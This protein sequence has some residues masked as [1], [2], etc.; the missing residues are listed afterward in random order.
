MSLADLVF[1]DGAFTGRRLS[2][3]AKGALV[4]RGA[5]GCLLLERQ[6]ESGLFLIHLGLEAALVKSLAHCADAP[7]RAPPCDEA[8]AAL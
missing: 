4:G 5:G 2:A 6:N 1:G 3:T 7:T 8:G